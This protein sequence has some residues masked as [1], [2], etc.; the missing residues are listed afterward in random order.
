VRLD[1][2]VAHAHVAPIRRSGRVADL[3]GVRIL[4]HPCGLP[5][6]YA[7]GGAVRGN[8]A[9]TF[10]RADLD[11]FGGNS[12]SPVF[13][14]DWTVEGLL[15]SGAPDFVADPECKCQRSLVIPVRD[16]T[17]DPPGEDCVRVTEL[18]G[19]VPAAAD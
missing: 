9:K 5:I 7:P 1:R 19:Y 18:A 6:K 13:G 8:N 12:G 17:T 4:G 11:A 14:D 16:G 3:T 10:F 15:I 2:A